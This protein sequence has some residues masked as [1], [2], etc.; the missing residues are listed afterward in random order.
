MLRVG[1]HFLLGCTSIINPFQTRH[2]TP[3]GYIEQLEMSVVPK[4]DDGSLEPG[5]MWDEFAK[6]AI[7]SGERFG[8]T[9][10]IQ[11]T[12]KDL[13][14]RAGFEDVVELK[15]KWP[16]GA[17]STDQ[18]LKDLG[19]WNMHHWNEGLEGWNIALL[20]RLMGVSRQ[21]H[22]GWRRTMLILAVVLQTSQRVECQN[23]T[24]DEGSEISRVSRS[25]R[26]TCF[27]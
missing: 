17:W 25:V 8:K 3:G 21:R 23:A 6:L 24:H 7:E 19:N 20:T 15:Y 12:M 14:T 18:K 13:I 9:F 1:H 27:F 4:S 10:Q 11:E 2:L 26:P 16:I 22:E 5:D